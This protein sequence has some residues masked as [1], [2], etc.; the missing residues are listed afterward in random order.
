MSK[1]LTTDD[2][3]NEAV[4]TRSASEKIDNTEQNVSDWL[5]NNE[6]SFLKCCANTVTAV[7]G[8]S[9]T[10]EIE[11]DLDTPQESKKSFAIDYNTIPKN[12][13]ALCTASIRSLG[14]IINDIRPEENTPEAEGLL[15]YGH[16]EDCDN[17]F[18]SRI[19][20]ELLKSISK[21]F[22]RRYN[23]VYLNGAF[24]NIEDMKSVI[25]EAYER[26]TTK[27]H[28]AKVVISLESMVK[29]D[30]G[31]VRTIGDMI[32]AGYIT[33]SIVPNPMMVEYRYR[34]LDPMLTASLYTKK[35]SGRLKQQTLEV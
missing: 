10:T 4:D 29:D 24:E 3:F 20:T 32:H 1:K 26:L 30:D 21:S 5:A 22:P 14:Y 15:L 11:Y 9:Y 13:L 2:L 34:R 17:E 19:D 35:L 7:Y 6:R 28:I 18:K 12:T 33:P 16:T 8:H 23:K 31:G 27:I 25:I